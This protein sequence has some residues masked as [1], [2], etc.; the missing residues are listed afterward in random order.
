M[1]AEHIS[2][3]IESVLSDVGTWPSEKERESFYLNLGRISRELEKI[4]EKYNG[5]TDT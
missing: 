5:N 4:C 2:Q 1:I 3:R